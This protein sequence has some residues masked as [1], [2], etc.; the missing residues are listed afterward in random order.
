MKTVVSTAPERVFLKIQHFPTVGS[1]SA[2]LT[3]IAANF[4][5][6]F[7]YSDSPEFENSRQR[8]AGS[9]DI[10]ENRTTSEIHQDLDQ[11]V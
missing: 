6:P 9:D 4:S 8:L 11:T 5:S 10:H 3:K 1:A 7:V 2:Y